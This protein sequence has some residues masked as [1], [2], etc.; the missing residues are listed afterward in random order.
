MAENKHETHKRASLCFYQKTD[1]VA[2]FFDV[3][4]STIPRRFT[5]SRTKYGVSVF[6][7]C[8]GNQTSRTA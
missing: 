4:G 8:T 1:I 7:S 5:I 3:L 2:I 6:Y